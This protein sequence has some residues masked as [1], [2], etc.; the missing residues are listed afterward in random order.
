MTPP[1]SIRSAAEGAPAA[2][3]AA[4]AEE[5]MREAIDFWRD[6]CTLCCER[7]ISPSCERERC[8]L[9]ERCERCEWCERC[10]RCERCEGVK[11]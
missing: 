1:P 10:E 8:E 2:A 3:T 7:S 11:V 5:V 6:S 4:S 9:C